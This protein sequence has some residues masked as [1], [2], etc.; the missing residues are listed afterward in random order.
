M[1]VLFPLRESDL[2]KG[3]TWE[4]KGSQFHLG[5]KKSK[6]TLGLTTGLCVLSLQQ[7]GEQMGVLASSLRSTSPALP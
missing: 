4:E 7:R 2:F 3:K 5:P 6:V 1:R